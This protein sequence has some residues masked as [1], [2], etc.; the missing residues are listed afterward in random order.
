MRKFL[1]E[2]IFPICGLNICKF[3]CL[4]TF[5]CNLKI[6]TPGAVPLSHKQE[7]TKGRKKFDLVSVCSQ[8]R[9]SKVTYWFCFSLAFHGFV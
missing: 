5:I 3:S 7:H 1:S 8:L 2:E 6:N 4:L 9:L